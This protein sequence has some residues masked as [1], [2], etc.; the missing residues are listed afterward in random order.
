MKRKMGRKLIFFLVIKQY[1]AA[2]LDDT[3]YCSFFTVSVEKVKSMK[4][5]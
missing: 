2:K 5:Q 1:R 4:K 3:D